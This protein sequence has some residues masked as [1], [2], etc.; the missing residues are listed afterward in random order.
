M[1][2][3]ANPGVAKVTAN[4]VHFVTDHGDGCP[5]DGPACQAKAYVMRGDTV[6]VGVAN[7][8]YVCAFLPTKGGGSAGWVKPAEI[9]EASVNA[10]PPL[11]A[12]SGAWRLGDARITLGVRDNALV[13]D[14]TV[15]VPGAAVAAAT[16]AKPATPAAGDT[17][18]SSTAPVAIPAPPPPGKMSGVAQPVGDSV[19][20]AAA[21]PNGCRVDL[22][23]IGPFLAAKDN[24]QCGGGARFAGVFR[25]PSAVSAGG[26]GKTAPSKSNPNKNVFY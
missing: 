24:G 13:A 7:G 25:R 15:P 6:M 19:E 2:E 14:G 23:L 9:A 1:T 4:E 11:E 5:S 26:P 12:W 22:R 17:T 20:F 16:M 3:T 21:D 18:A 8:P 10:T